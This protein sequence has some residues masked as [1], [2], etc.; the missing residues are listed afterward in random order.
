MFGKGKKMVGMK[1]IYNRMFLKHFIYT[2]YKTFNG[3]S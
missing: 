3:K 2:I 1:A